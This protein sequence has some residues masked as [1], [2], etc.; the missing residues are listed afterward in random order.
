M[1]TLIIISMLGILLSSC[2]Q[3][4]V[5]FTEKLSRRYNWGESGL[6]KIQFFTSN[7]I[8]IQRRVNKDEVEIVSGKIKIVD[9]K[10]VEEVLVK[11]GTR[12]VA[13][14]F[15]KD[16]R[17]GI[18]FEIDDEHY[19]TFGPNPKKTEKYYLLA[20]Q[21]KNKIGKVMYNGQE[22]F[23]S[24]QSADVYLMVDMKKLKKWE[25]DQRIAKGREID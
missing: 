2:T 9:G 22:Y 17:L 20:S 4:L 12:G 15:P 8:I 7:D 6:S 10:E 5:P 16:D 19:L 24:P 21:W 18:S 14:W 11:K 3:N 23:T 25:V 1:R 13:V